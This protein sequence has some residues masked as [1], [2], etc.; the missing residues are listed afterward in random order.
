[1]SC[2]PVPGTFTFSSQLSHKAA[3]VAAPVYFL[4]ATW[5]SEDH[6]SYALDCIRSK[7][8]QL[9]RGIQFPNCPCRIILLEILYRH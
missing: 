3:S 8:S 5:F 1:M 4:N 2:S 9:S 7:M 6:R